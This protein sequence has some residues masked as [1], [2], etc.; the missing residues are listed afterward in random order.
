MPKLFQ[1]NVEANYGSTGRIASGIGDLVLKNGWESY[2]AYGQKQASS[3]S[4]LS[5]VGGKLDFYNHVIHTRLFDRHGLASLKP[6]DK[7][8]E[9]IKHIQPDIV[10]LH[11]IH[12]YYLNYPRLFNFLGS[13]DI[14]IVW[15]LHDCWA[16]TGHCTHF[17]NIDCQR[18]Q[19]S[20]HSCPQKNVY[21]SSILRDR[22]KKNHADKKK[23][24]QLPKKIEIVTVSNWLNQV[25]GKS[26][27]SGYPRKTIHN[28]LDIEVFRP[29]NNISLIEKFDLNDSLVF[30]GVASVWAENKGLGDFIRLSEHLAENEKIVLIGLKK[31]Q[32]AKLP[33]NIIGLERTQN[34]EELAAWYSISDI[35]INTS[36]EESF[37]MTTAE[38]MACGTPVVVYNSTACPEMVNSKVGEIVE[39]N[40]IEGLRNALNTILSKPKGWYSKNCREFVVR[41]FNKEERYNDYFNLYNTL[42]NAKNKTWEKKIINN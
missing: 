15:T 25:V 18:W 6:T 20:C 16:L 27:L 31:E 34:I 1:I 37:G 30:L 19:T 32:I 33:E 40:D 36:V 38:A 7:L 11:N 12:G 22:S 2:I 3:N 26:F 21:P 9:K 14:P 29:S 42:L 41:N 28:G 35:Y 10:H 13:S 24:F 8:I 39:K 5:K 4:E 23:Y 17:E